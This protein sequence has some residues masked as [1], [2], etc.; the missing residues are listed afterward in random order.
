MGSLQET[1]FAKPKV[2]IAPTLHPS[3]KAYCSALGKT[4]WAPKSSKRGGEKRLDMRNNMRVR[5]CVLVECVRR[6]AG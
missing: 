1:L 6:H 4:S 2:E 3:W 5:I